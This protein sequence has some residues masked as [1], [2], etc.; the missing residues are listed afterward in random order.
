MVQ[1][2]LPVARKSTG[3]LLPSTHELHS[4]CLQMSQ[5]VAYQAPSP[6]AQAPPAADQ[7]L[8][9]AA[10]APPAADQATLLPAAQAPPAADQ[11]LLPAPLLGQGNADDDGAAAA[12]ELDADCPALELP[13]GDGGVRRL[14]VCACNPDQLWSLFLNQRIGGGYLGKSVIAFLV[15]KHAD[16]AAAY[17]GRKFCKTNFQTL[18]EQKRC[19]TAHCDFQHNFEAVQDFIISKIPTLVSVRTKVMCINVP[20]RLGEAAEAARRAA[21][22]A[23]AEPVKATMD[24]NLH[25]RVVQ[26]V[27][28]S[29]VEPSLSDL[30]N[31]YYGNEHSRNRHAQDTA[32]F[33]CACVSLSLSSPSLLPVRHISAGPPISSTR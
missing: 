31:R 21:A 29:Q 6:A 2:R 1:R 28:Y 23:A 22:L 33:R 12:L 11:A 14:D 32:G 8:L 17:P 16:F 10:Q 15:Q 30:F 24:D 20:A 27:K 19:F 7:A 5:D 4:T 18:I 26:F 3:D 13:R 25:C 9:P